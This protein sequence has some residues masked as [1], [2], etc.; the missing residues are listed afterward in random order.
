[1]KSTPKFPVRGVPGGWRDEWS[2]PD[3]AAVVRAQFATWAASNAAKAARA[4]EGAASSES[5]VPSPN[6]RPAIDRYILV[7]VSQ[8]TDDPSQH[9]AFALRARYD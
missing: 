5:A 1:M 8:P 9:R 7:G 6:G 2:A 3:D 4:G